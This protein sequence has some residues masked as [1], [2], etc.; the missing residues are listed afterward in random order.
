MK[1]LKF[2]EKRWKKK[3]LFF[4][5][6]GVPCFLLTTVF[7]Y[8]HFCLFTDEFIQNKAVFWKLTSL[9]FFDLYHFN[10]NLSREKY[11]LARIVCRCKKVSLY[12]CV[13]QLDV[14]W[15]GEIYFHSFTAHK[16]SFPLR[17]SSENMTR[18]AGNCGFGHIYRRNL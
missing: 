8:S 11:F 10:E 1:H 15:L 14:E 17:I 7:W 6:F 4:G 13:W 18:F 9:C 12:F 16:W 3:C 5:K 2:S